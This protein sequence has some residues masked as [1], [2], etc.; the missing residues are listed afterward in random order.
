M[1]MLTLGKM[2]F[3]K[4]TLVIK[5]ILPFIELLQWLTILLNHCQVTRPI[6]KKGTKSSVPR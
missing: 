3:G 4:L 2:I 6:S 1:T 5:A